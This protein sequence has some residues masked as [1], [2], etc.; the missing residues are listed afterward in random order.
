[1]ELDTV[2][3][4]FL[5]VLSSFSEVLDN[6]LDIVMSSLFRDH[7]WLETFG[8]VNLSG[9]SYGRRAHWDTTPDVKWV[10]GS[11]SVPYLIEEQSPLLMHSFHYFLPP[12]YLLVRVYPTAAGIRMCP[13]IHR[14]GLSQNQTCSNSLSVVLDMQRSGDTVIWVGSLSRKRSHHNSVLEGV[15]TF[16][17]GF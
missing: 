17:E 4:C 11:S 10:C 3:P 7:M 1:M 13:R 6:M 15:D 9:S 8:S 12:L 2:K 5:S 14:S 16:L